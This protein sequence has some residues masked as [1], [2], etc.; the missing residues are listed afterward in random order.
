MPVMVIPLLGVVFVTCHVACRVLY[1]KWANVGRVKS[2][3]AEELSGGGEGRRAKGEGRKE[4]RE[5][6][7]DD[8]E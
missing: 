5:V 4:G 3:G 7:E 1:W 8:G 6:S 2:G